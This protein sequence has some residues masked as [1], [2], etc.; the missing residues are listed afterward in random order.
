M[1]Y[2]KNKQVALFKTSKY[3]N[4][5]G[6]GQVL[7]GE[8]MEGEINVGNLF[9]VKLNDIKATYRI[10]AVESVDYPLRNEVE[11]GLIIE[12]LEPDIEVDLQSII[13]QTIAILTALQAS[14]QGYR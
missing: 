10:D 3:F 11:T 2:T 6:I 9:Q 8:I 4:I 5:V 12:A 7:T 1:P 14:K 13:G